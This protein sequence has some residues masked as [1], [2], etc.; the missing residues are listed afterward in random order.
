M[1]KKFLPAAIAAATL[2]M[3]IAG[4]AQTTGTD[5]AA[6]YSGNYAGDNNGTGFGAFAV[7]SNNNGGPI[8]AG[9]FI[10]S[11]GGAGYNI[12]T[13][14]NSFGMYANGDPSATVTITRPFQ[15]ALQNPGDQFNVALRTDF[16]NSTAGQTF[17]FVVGPETLT[18]ASTGYTLSGGT[19]TANTLAPGDFILNT[20]FTI[21]AANT[22]TF[23]VTG[24]NAG[25]AATSTGTLTGPVGQFQV[26]GTDLPNNQYF[27]SLSITNNPAPAPEPSSLAAL[28]IGALALGGAVCVRRRQSA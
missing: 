6:T 1:M 7:T 4:H 16:S 19:V 17:Q 26:G 10:G 13:G 5:T 2:L 20:S 24:N 23:T 27:N 21:G 25:D 28:L 9:T 14:G 22:Y 3:P 15:T 11:S 8:Y 12:D 18:L